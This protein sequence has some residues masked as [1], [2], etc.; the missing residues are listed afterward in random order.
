M[1]LFLENHAYIFSRHFRNKR[2][3]LDKMTNFRQNKNKE[4][5]KYQPFRCLIEEA[6]KY[7]T[8]QIRIK[9]NNTFFT[10]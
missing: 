7:K 4:I 3:L 9:K 8:K 2:F 10:F 5:L 1:H 6:G